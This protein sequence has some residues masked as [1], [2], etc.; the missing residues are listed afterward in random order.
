MPHNKNHK[1]EIPWY[2]PEG[3]EYTGQDILDSELAG[4]EAINDPIEPVNVEAARLYG[5]KFDRQAAA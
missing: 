2:W 5:D 4:D 3:V 1:Q